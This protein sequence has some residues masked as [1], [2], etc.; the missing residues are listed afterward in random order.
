LSVRRS[1]G[2]AAL[3]LL[4]LLG[5]GCLEFSEEAYCAARPESCTL[6]VTELT[7]AR[8]PVVGGTVVHVVGT[9]FDPELTVEVE[10]VP[11]ETLVSGSRQLTFVTPAHVQGLRDV[12]F[13]G[14]FETV[15]LPQAFHYGPRPQLSRFAPTSGSSLG[16][17]TVTFAGTELGLA[18]QVKIGG[19]PVLLKPQAAGTPTFSVVTPAM[20]PGTYDVEV[21]NDVGET[22]RLQGAFRYE[23]P[24][25]ERSAGLLGANVRALWVD[26]QEPSRVLAGPAG[27]GLF[28]SLDGGATWTRLGNALQNQN[29]D[30]LHY[31][32]ASG[33]LYAG[34]PLG[35]YRSTNRGDDWT[36]LNEGLTGVSSTST[37]AVL[38]LTQGPD[39][40]LYAV[41]EDA[42]ARLAPG[43]SRWEYFLTGHEQDRTRSASYTSFA[44]TT[45]GFFLGTSGGLYVRARTSDTWQ[46]VLPSTFEP[47]NMLVAA[48]GGAGPV[49]QASPSGLDKVELGQGPVRLFGGAA[50]PFAAVDPSVAGRLY[51]GTAE[52]LRVSDDAG[53]SWAPMPGLP[54]IAPQALGFGAGGR[55]LAGTAGAG[56]FLS[57]AGAP[58]VPRNAGLAA[59]EVTAL[60]VD[61]AAPQHLYAGTSGGLFQSQD[62]GG[63]WTATATADV[64]PGVSVMRVHPAAP[65]SIYVGTSGGL[66][67]SVDAGATWEALGPPGAVL[68]LVVVPT[69]PTAL[70]L[71]NAAGVWSSLDDG[72]SWLEI[73]GG[74][75]SFLKLAVGAGPVFP[76]YAV[77]QDGYLYRRSS[78]GW[79]QVA[80]TFLAVRSLAGLVSPSEGKTWL[81]C[82]T[83][84]CAVS[85]GSDSA[86]QELPRVPF[87]SGER[88]Q[89]LA[90]T[91][92]PDDTV[93]VGSSLSLY[94]RSLEAGSASAWDDLSRGLPA[95]SVLSI[96]VHPREP[97]TIYIGTRGQG[98]HKST[99][100]G[101]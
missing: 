12:T 84:G 39:Q 24:W 35:C 14:R 70:Y 31:D 50:V 94:R 43:A 95:S 18:P 64:P 59:A 79:Q 3:L 26:P 81:G 60:L 21:T 27:G 63:L 93:L 55:L 83:G 96:A 9:A 99:I 40:V 73:S 54:V 62:E 82:G 16:G 76:V 4:G 36:Q 10:G 100:Q 89:S 51:L 74:S 2:W 66:R 49:Y 86:W 85:R 17:T 22:L 48:P 61:P 58:F 33:A 91:D 5:A 34:T 38:A 6:Q 57:D 30:V 97:R 11:A 29:V 41:F 19:V 78:A 13:R 42:V 20:S 80:Y 90:L 7:P 87:H 75:T 98:V 101:L 52:G 77:K 44:A 37:L 28:R 23:V 8:G 32:A 53:S 71:L 46:K 88:I 45:P 1:G 15:T 72:Q 92:A 69:S 68:D 47:V 67:R 56:A 25:V 65:R